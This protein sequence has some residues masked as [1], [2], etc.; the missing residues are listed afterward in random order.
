VLELYAGAATHSVVVCE[1]LQN[2][3]TGINVSRCGVR[4]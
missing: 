1:V 4:A 2:I 3:T